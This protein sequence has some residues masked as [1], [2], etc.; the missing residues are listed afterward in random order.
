MDLQFWRLQFIVVG[1]SMVEWHR[2]RQ[3]Q[4]EAEAV[5]T[6]VDLKQRDAAGSQEQS[7]PGESSLPPQSSATCE[8]GAVCCIKSNPN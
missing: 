6:V 3:P 5:H 2:Q 8:N 4:H 7:R 1:Q